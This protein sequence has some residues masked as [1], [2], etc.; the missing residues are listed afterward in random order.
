MDVSA[1]STLARRKKHVRYS[2]EYP[3][4]AIGSMSWTIADV[5]AYLEYLSHEPEDGAEHNGSSGG[6]TQPPTPYHVYT[7]TVMLKRAFERYVVDGG[8]KEEWNRATGH[9]KNYAQSKGWLDDPSTMTADEVSKT[10]ELFGCT[11]DYL[12]YGDVESGDNMAEP[13][14]TLT[15]KGVMYY[16]NLLNHDQREILTATILQFLYANNRAG[17]C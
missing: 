16:W 14:G 8:T 17:I 12:R 10:C 11:L 1:F 2:D 4:K 6:M 3:L 9:G 7:P 13:D 5:G 15:C